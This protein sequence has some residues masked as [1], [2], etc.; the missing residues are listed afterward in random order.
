MIRRYILAPYYLVDRNLGV[1]ETIKIA[2]KES[3]KL[4]G[5]LWGLLGVEIL[6]GITALVPILGPAVFAATQ[7][8]YAC[9][10]AVRYYE[11]KKLGLSV[12]D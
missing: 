11:Y 8:I 3:S 1:I 10:P 2:G 7:L 5:P 9:A 4:P 6:L 12:K